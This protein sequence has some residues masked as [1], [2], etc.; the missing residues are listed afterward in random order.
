M[1]LIKVIGHQSLF[2][3]APKEVGVVKYRTNKAIELCTLIERKRFVVVKPLPY[4][5]RDLRSCPKITINLVPRLKP[6][7]LCFGLADL[8]DLMELPCKVNQTD[9]DGESA[10]YIA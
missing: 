6:L 8:V 7:A 9:D 3:Q 4:Q 2:M 1:T 5:C 10:K